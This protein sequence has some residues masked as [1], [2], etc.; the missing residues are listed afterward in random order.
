MRHSMRLVWEHISL[1]LVRPKLR[2][3]TKISKAG[4]YEPRPN[5]SGQMA[6]NVVVW[7]PSLIAAWVVGQVLLSYVVWQLSVCI[8]HLSV[9]QA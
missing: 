1:S 2:M 5:C 8:F 4:S 7:L 3:G 9:T 6:I